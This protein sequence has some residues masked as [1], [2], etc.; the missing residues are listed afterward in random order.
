MQLATNLAPHASV[1]PFYHIQ[2]H[3]N[4]RFPSTVNLLYSQ[5]CILFDLLRFTTRIAQL[6]IVAAVMDSFRKSA[7]DVKYIYL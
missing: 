7:H 2:A 5:R 6:V 3:H 1:R 4:R